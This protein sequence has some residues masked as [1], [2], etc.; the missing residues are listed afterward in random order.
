MCAL[1]HV[2]QAEP[3]IINQAALAK[4]IKEELDTLLT[5]LS[6]KTGKNRPRGAERKKMW[7]EV[8]ALRKEC[9][10]PAF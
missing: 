6:G 8:K 9:A 4:D 7:E 1:R 2:S 10:P 3:D 5:S